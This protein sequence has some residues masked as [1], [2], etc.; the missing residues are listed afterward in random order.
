MSSEV[1]REDRF[2]EDAEVLVH[3]DTA[4]VEAPPAAP[5]R[6]PKSRT[7]PPKKKR[8]PKPPPRWEYHVE[9]LGEEQPTGW[10]RPRD[11]EEVTA[12]EARLNEL[13][14]DGWE[15]V[16]YGRSP[17]RVWSEQPD[18]RLVALFKRP[19]RGV[20]SPGPGEGAG[21]RERRRWDRRL[22]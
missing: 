1:R 18:P 9:L 10:Y 2:R 4:A 14:G 13:G 16:G 20:V 6:A 22:I 3:L 19:A 7:A 21:P 11:R 15:L 5:A 17:L 8:P 12:L